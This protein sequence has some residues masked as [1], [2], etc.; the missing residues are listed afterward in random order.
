MEST[1]SFLFLHCIN[2]L[3]VVLTLS[4]T[5]VKWWLF[6]F[7]HF[8]TFFVFRRICTSVRLG[9]LACLFVL[10]HVCFSSVFCTPW[11]DATLERQRM[12]QNALLVVY[13]VLFCYLDSHLIL[14]PSSCSLLLL[15]FLCTLIFP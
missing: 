8:F 11:E 7:L 1:K 10:W 14:C 15:L 4:F 12:R 5:E 3:I 2:G 9:L 6:F 13:I